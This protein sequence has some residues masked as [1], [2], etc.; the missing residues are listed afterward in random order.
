M[1]TVQKRS[2]V[3]T[4]SGIPTQLL[5]VAETSSCRGNLGDGESAR[6][7]GRPRPKG[8][9]SEQYDGRFSVS[10]FTVAVE[11]EKNS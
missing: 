10:A 1:G 11:I 7:V 5:E 2:F 3:K 6:L 4:P 9:L 8:F